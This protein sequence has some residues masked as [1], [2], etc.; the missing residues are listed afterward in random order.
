MPSKKDIFHIKAQGSEHELRDNRPL[1][2]DCPFP[3]KI[4][5]YLT[6][7][8]IEQIHVSFVLNFLFVH[9]CQKCHRPFLV[10][11]SD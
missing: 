4:K 10:C 5:H 3:A 9:G 6:S 7:A 2:K 11:D 1:R 8:V